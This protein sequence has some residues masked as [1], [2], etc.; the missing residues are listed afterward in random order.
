MSTLEVMLPLIFQEC[1]SLLKRI[2][3]QQF[4]G[5]NRFH[6]GENRISWSLSTSL[7]QP[8]LIT[9]QISSSHESVWLL[10]IEHLGPLSK[11]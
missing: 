7:C 9:A 3:L 10:A 1:L 4:S 5:S 11:T 8:V 6:F 2:A